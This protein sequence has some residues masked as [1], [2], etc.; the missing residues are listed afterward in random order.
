MRGGFL[1][2]ITESP[3]FYSGSSFNNGL[4][5]AGLIKFNQWANL[6]EI[7]AML[8]RFARWTLTD[9]WVAPN[10]IASK[11]GSIN[12]GGS[13]QH[14]SIHSRLM[15][16]TYER[17]KD[18]LYLVVPW[19]LTTAGYGA[20]NSKPI[21]GTRS[22]GLVYNY[23]PWLI[24]KFSEHGNPQPEAELDITVKDEKVKLEPG[25][26]ARIDFV[27]KNSGSEPIEDLNATFRMR[28]DYIVMERRAL[29]TTLQPG[30]SAQCSYDIQAPTQV[31]LSCAYNAIAYG[32]WSSLYRRADHARLRA[33]LSR[34]DSEVQIIAWY[35]AM[36][37]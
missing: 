2:P 30:E 25:G 15:A 33:S 9:V 13:P 18:P 3:A 23:L 26:V 20:S 5:S 21:P 12:K 31:N 36:S 37:S 34:S 7:D 11:G 10:A 22:V 29:P 8:E 14:I 24:S 4:L 19:K 32:H 35:M 17:T 16:D 6:P 28:L 1:A 27:I